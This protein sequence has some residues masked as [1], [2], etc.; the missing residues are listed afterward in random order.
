MSPALTYFIL[1]SS[2]LFKSSLFFNEKKRKRKVS[3]ATP[4]MQGW[5]RRGDHGPQPLPRQI[6]LP[7]C[8]YVQFSHDSKIKI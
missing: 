6:N 7:F 3:K 8:V 5:G 1:C 2:T 4:N